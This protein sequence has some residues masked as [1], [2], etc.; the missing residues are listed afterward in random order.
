MDGLPEVSDTASGLGVRVGAPPD[1]DI[2]VVDGLVYP[3]TGGMSVV[4]DNPS[5]LPRHRCPPPLGSRTNHR[6]FLI[7]ET[8][9][10]EQLVA[11]QDRPV[12]NPAHR[13]IEPSNSCPIESF[14]QHL[15]ST[16]SDWRQL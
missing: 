10:P 11:R 1:G 15:V 3:R 6:I 13:S 5:C 2:P 9:L 16:R 7:D 8:A 4:A 14:R 12:D